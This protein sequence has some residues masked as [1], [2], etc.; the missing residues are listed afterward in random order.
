MNDITPSNHPLDPDKSYKNDITIAAPQLTR[1]N[2]QT[3]PRENKETAIASSIIPWPYD[4]NKSMYLGCRA[5]GF[6]VRE[7]MRAV[8]VSK[9][10]VSNWR[11]EDAE[12][13]RIENNLPEIRKALAKDYI[14]LEFLR[15][16][17]MVLE[18]D[19]RV[20]EKALGYIIKWNE[21]EGKN[22]VQELSREEHDYLLKM[23]SQYTPESFKALE[24][25]VGHSEGFNFTDMVSGVDFTQVVGQRTTTIT[26][27]LA[28]RKTE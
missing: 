23:R 22:E 27:T 4:D 2:K 24:T 21:E 14:E 19:R 25:I 3:L 20:L 9:G 10:A 13:V 11:A 17:R 8:G 12:F 18:K 15:N 26:E 1:T 28:A 6:S 7:A 5:C 16:F